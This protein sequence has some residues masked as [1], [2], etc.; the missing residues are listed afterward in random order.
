MDKIAWRSDLKMLIE[1][2]HHHRFFRHG[3]CFLPTHRLFTPRSYICLSLRKGEKK[4]FCRDVKNK[5]SGI[6]CSGD[7]TIGF[8]EQGNMIL[9][10]VVTTPHGHTSPLF[11]WLSHGHNTELH[12]IFRDRPDAN[13]CE[14]SV[15]ST[16]VPH[17]MLDRANFIWQTTFIAPWNL[18]RLMQSN[19]PTHPFRPVLW[20]DHVDLDSPALTQNQNTQPSPHTRI[21][22]HHPDDDTVSMASVTT[23]S[24]LSI[25][26][27]DKHHSPLP[28]TPTMGCSTCLKTLLANILV[29]LEV[30]HPTLDTYHNRETQPIDSLV[31][32]GD[33]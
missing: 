31:T 32:A 10:P 25:I 28:P 14:E 16:K 19:G 30:C 12:Q 17:N 2:H 15:R 9:V 5:Q 18:W 1:N 21:H 22:P 7:E 20:I 3:Y 29:L 4:K 24:S 6:S 33:I 27:E 23:A 11:N 8:I 13:I 26:M